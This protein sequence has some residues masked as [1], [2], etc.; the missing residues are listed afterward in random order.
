M[1]PVAAGLALSFE[2]CALRDVDWLLSYYFEEEERE[3]KY[4]ANVLYASRRSS[5]AIARVHK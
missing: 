1:A 4:H 3:G 5:A 2:A